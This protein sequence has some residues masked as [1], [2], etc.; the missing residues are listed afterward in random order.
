MNARG[1]GLRGG[2]DSLSDG[3]MGWQVSAQGYWA[4]GVLEILQLPRRDTAQMLNIMQAQ[5]RATAPAL[6]SPRPRFLFLP[7]LV[8]LP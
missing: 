2:K 5:V 6:Q 4:G 7:C 8:Q 1:L 3:D